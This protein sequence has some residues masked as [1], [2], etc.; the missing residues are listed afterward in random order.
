[1][2]YPPAEYLIGRLNLKVADVVTPTVLEDI[3]TYV[4]LS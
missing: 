4:M 3:V 1:M 2:M